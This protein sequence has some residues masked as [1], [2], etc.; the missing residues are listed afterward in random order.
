M[1]ETYKAVI[2]RIEPGSQ[3][4]AKGLQAGDTI[5][6]VNGKP[7][8]D[9]IDLNYELADENISVVVSGHDG[10]K[11]CYFQKRFGEDLGITMESAVFDSI[12]Q[13]RNGCIFCFIAQMPQ[14][15]RP[16]LYVR[17]DDYRM[18]FLTGSFITLSNL[19]KDDLSRIR[20]YHLSPLH[21]SVHTVNGS[22]RR[23][24]MRQPDT[25]HI[26]E[27]LEE[28][29]RYDID[30]YCQIV[31]VPGYNDGVEFEHTLQYLE[32]LRPNV[33]GIAV[34]PLGMTKFREQCEKLQ[35]VSVACAQETIRIA[36]AF[37]QR[38]RA[39]HGNSFVYLAD[40]FYLKAQQP[41]PE[42]E[43]YDGYEQIEDGIGMIRLFEQQWHQ[44]S[45]AMRQAYDKPLRLALFTGTLVAPFIQS[46]VDEVQVEN[47]SVSVIAV[48]NEY[49]G[50]S[51]NVT[52][53]LTAQDILAAYNHSD[54]PWD[55]VIIPGTALRKGEDIF[56]DD[57]TLAEFC[58]NI[59]VPVRVSEFA[60]DLKEILY[61]WHDRIEKD[62][63]SVSHP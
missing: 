43:W 55:G 41:I 61:H 59:G 2:S 17:D 38:S 35:P 9:L 3:A 29:V 48:E 57:M 13:C 25:E 10:P 40:E 26:R 32:S 45:G 53:L 34:V 4:Q 7:V 52:G 58:C 21:V 60:S 22:L 51:I 31:L 39:E 63:S 62:T 8:Q 19:T 37:Q 24:M 16:S 1:T 47:L 15:M 12:E 14:G 30:M 5:V 18:S 23:R 44:W 42:N 20:R 11:E 56:L 49:F 46:M 50:P 6:S 33:L 54:G 28:L 27:Q 36:T